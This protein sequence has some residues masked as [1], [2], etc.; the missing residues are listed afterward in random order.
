M[1][2]GP[3]LARSVTLRQGWCNRCG[4][5]PHT[6]H[7]DGTLQE[8]C[9]DSGKAIKPLFSPY[10][11]SFS[12]TGHLIRQRISPLVREKIGNPQNFLLFLSG[13]L[14][15]KRTRNLMPNRKLEAY[16]ITGP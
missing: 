6:P 14:L 4:R 5:N 9:I 1:K 2:F 16:T 7:P 13:A 11:N 12:P 8:Y 15:P 10:F 3:Q